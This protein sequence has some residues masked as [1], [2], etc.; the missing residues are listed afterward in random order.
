MMLASLL[1][2]CAGLRAVG[3]QPDPRVAIV[4][5]VA[6]D[7]VDAGLAPAA[8]ASMLAD[9]FQQAGGAAPVP[10]S[11]V[12]DAVGEERLDALAGEL[13][14]SAALSGASLQLLMASP[15]PARRGLLVRLERNET[16]ILE[17][18]AAA[19][20]D[21]DGRVLSDRHDVILSSR[22]DMRLAASLIDLNRGSIVWQRAWT[23]A[24][25]VSASYVN[26]SG[27]SF[28]GSVAATLANTVVN[29]LRAPA[30]PPPAS[31]RDTL[32]A[33]FRQLIDE[34]PGR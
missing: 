21:A 7:G 34:L 4:A 20:R 3:S 26:Y 16:T 23:A 12:A 5:V 22:R 25:V 31:S 11:V 18:V 8:M 9:G 30:A 1:C 13:S 29:G 33:L 6:A 32:E 2:G 14:R 28:T 15:V 17:P 27:S 24:P 10:R 19:R